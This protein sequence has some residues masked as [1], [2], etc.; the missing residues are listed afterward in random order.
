MTRSP[1]FWFAAGIGAT[2]AYHHWMKPLPA[3]KGA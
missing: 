1:I 2:W 3:A